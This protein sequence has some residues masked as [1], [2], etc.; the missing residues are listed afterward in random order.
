[1]KSSVKLSITALFI[2]LMTVFIISCLKKTD[3]QNN[4]FEIIKETATEYSVSFI[5]GK[6]KY[7]FT[8][9]LEAGKTIS[10]FDIYNNNNSTTIKLD[11]TIDTSIPDYRLLQHGKI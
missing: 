7:F 2:I 9:Q 1:L 6:D 11:Y 4:K 3:Y 10:H 8:S 5:S